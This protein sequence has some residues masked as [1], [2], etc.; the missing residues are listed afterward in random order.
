MVSKGHN[1]FLFASGDSR[2][3]ARLISVTDKATSLDLSINDKARVDYEHLLISK[4][5]SMAKQGFF[6]LIHSIY[7][8]RS[9]FYTQFVS[10]PTIS[11]LHSP[12]SDHKKTI[13]ENFKKNQYYVSI[14]NAQRKPIPDLNYVA[15]IYHG[16]QLDDNSL[17]FG[18]GKLDYMIF[19]GRLTPEKGIKN[20]I[21]LAKKLQ[22]KVYL[23]GTGVETS[24][25]WNTEVKPNID[26]RLIFHSGFLPKEKLGVYYQ[27]AKL[28]I[29]PIQW[30]EPFG[31]VMIEAMA[32]GTP[33]V[34]FARGSVPEVIKDGET[35]FI[36]NSSDDDIRGNWIIK[37]TGIE[38]LCEAVERIYSL[39]EKQYQEMRYACRKHVEKHF[40]VERMVD[41]YEKVYEKVIRLNKQRQS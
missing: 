23:L 33:V 24:D 13:L 16:I 26:N 2:T 27:N 11:T 18:E 12:L 21:N 8:I 31:L 9:A 36:V 35:G 30:E 38:G 1:V 6:E 4:C 25:F 3:A 29:F 14:S 41:E 7:D 28:F 15:T 10:T 37:K 19:V 22:K 17:S 39:P 34:A 32:C 20:I 5:Y 40:T